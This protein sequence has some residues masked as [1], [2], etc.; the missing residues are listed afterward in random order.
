MAPG[1][2]ENLIL[3][4][5]WSSD[6]HGG[7]LWGQDGSAGSWFQENGLLCTLT[8]TLRKHPGC[9]HYH[10]KA[11]QHP[12]TLELTVDPTQELVWAEVRSNRHG[13]AV[14]G[15]LTGLLDAFGPE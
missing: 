2:R 3:Y 12:G 1:E 13:E 8:G 10:F 6:G 11:G 5:C 7:R 4:L 9:L 15:A 14:V